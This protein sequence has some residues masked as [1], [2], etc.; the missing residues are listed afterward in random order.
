MII[1]DFSQIV[2]SSAMAYFAQTKEKVDT[3]LLRHIA[4]NNIINFKKKFGKEFNN[5]VLCFDG[6]DY[7]RRDLFPYYKKHRAKAREDSKFDWE[8]F[9]VSFNQIKKE[10]KEN[11]P[12]K[13]LEH[14]K[15]EADDIVATLC[16]EYR[17]DEIIII[18]SD[19]DFNQLHRLSPKIKQYSV[20][21][22]KFVDDL[23]Y[24]LF[25]HIVKGDA[26]DGIPNIFTDDDV[27]VNPEKRSKPVRTETLKK[28]EELYGLTQPEMF[29]DT[30]EQ[31]DKFHRNR[32]LVDLTLVP[33]ELRNEILELFRNFPDNKHKTFNY[34]IEN[35]LTKIM[36]AG[37]V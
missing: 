32:N 37:I 10:F 14:S 7:W 4:L 11:L 9:F 17:S 12:Y 13:V 5:V 20:K 16:M 8:T 23:D 28:W 22:K 33:I 24:S 31:L 1:I 34:L 6:K 36:E 26:G 3:P 19:H 21:T 35:K 27:F 25:E 2:M 15:A 18:S 30:S 29:C